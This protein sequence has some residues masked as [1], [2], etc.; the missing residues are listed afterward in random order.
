LRRLS[1]KKTKTRGRGATDQKSSEN[2]LLER[3]ER[4]REGRSQGKSHVFKSAERGGKYGPINLSDEKELSREQM[5]YP[6]ERSDSCTGDPLCKRRGVLKG[7]GTYCV[8]TR[9]RKGS[10]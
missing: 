2:G 1:K 8:V 9:R 4:R 5:N 7:E 3:T 10:C 6:N